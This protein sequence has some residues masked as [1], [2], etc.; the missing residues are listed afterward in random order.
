MLLTTRE[1][2]TCHD[3]QFTGVW[4]DVARIRLDGEPFVLS[5]GISS[6]TLSG[7]NRQLYVT[8]GG[9]L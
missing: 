4:Y 9:R 6:Y 7:D 5:S 3:V 1:L 8:Y 2:V